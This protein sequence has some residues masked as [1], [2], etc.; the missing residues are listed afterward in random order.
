[1]VG[2]VRGLLDEVG[3]R[4]DEA[5]L[6]RGARSRAA[7]ARRGRV[8]RRK[9]PGRV[10]RGSFGDDAERVVGQPACAEL[11]R[12]RDHRAEL[13]HPEASRRPCPT[14]SCASST[15]P[16]AVD[17]DPDRDR[18]RAPAR[19]STSSTAA[20]TRSPTRLTNRLI[21]APPGRGGRGRRRLRPGQLLGSPLGA[22]CRRAARRLRLEQPHAS[23]GER[24][25]VAGRA[26]P[27][28][29]RTRARSPRASR[30]RSRP[31]ADGIRSRWRAR[32]DESS[33]RYG[34]TTA[35]ASAHQLRDLVLGNEAEP[36]LDS[37]VERRRCSRTGSSGSP[38]TTS[39]ASGISRQ[40]PQQDVEPL[41]V[42]DQAEE[43]ERAALGRRQLARPRRPGAGCARSARGRGRARRAARRRDASGRRRARRSRARSGQ[44]R[45]GRARRGR[46]S[47]AVSTTRPV[48]GDRRSQRRSSSGRGSHWTWTT[49]GSSRSIR[50]SEA[51]GARRRTRAA[52]SGQ[53]QARA[54]EEPRRD[55][56][57]QLLALVALGLGRVAVREAR[58][59]ERDRV[60]RAPRAPTPARGR[61][62]AC[63]RAGRRAR[64]ASDP[65][66]QVAE[67]GER[68]R[69]VV[70]RED[71]AHL[72]AL[73]VVAQELARAA[74]RDACAICAET[75][76]SFAR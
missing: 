24:I 26:R 22:R 30:R 62:A 33:R 58:G 42:A 27:R 35:A 7:A 39:R 57:E 63:R 61:T 8:R 73:E 18:P 29:R 37:L 38:A 31:R 48:V 34:S 11:E 44:T 15:G 50:R 40:R 49:S 51:R 23:C 71:G 1:M 54:P 14:R 21:A 76:T 19:S 32:P 67:A 45:A 52:F 53:A 6:R 74:A 66:A 47:C 75:Q 25:G 56:R 36:P 59:E 10:M 72:L 9:R 64:C 17:Q 41:V 69:R 4:A 12:V 5:H 55:R 13:Q 68:G 70:R 46:T 3:P 2:V 28:P 20:A 65:R 16:A 43:E 60:A